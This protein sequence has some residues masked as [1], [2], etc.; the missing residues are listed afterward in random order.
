MSLV[1]SL[2]PSALMADVSNDHSILAHEFRRGLRILSSEAL[3]AATAGHWELTFEMN[4][5]WHL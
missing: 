1:P 4:C 5:S 2:Q 3:Q